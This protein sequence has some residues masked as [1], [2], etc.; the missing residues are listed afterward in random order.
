MAEL[1]RR[2]TTD[3]GGFHPGFFVHIFIRGGEGEGG[4]TVVVV[5]EGHFWGTPAGDFWLILTKLM[6]KMGRVLR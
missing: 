4:L 1:W 5:F 2:C 3:A 6:Y